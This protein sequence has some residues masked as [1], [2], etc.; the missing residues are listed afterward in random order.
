MEIIICSFLLKES[1]AMLSELF[2]LLSI[3]AD[4]A[5]NLNYEKTIIK[6]FSNFVYIIFA[7]YNIT[8]HYI[9][10][11]MLITVNKRTV[12]L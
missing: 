1:K 2:A 8:L 3:E 10:F 7:S 6:D 12:F 11:N 4:T 9:F 5:S